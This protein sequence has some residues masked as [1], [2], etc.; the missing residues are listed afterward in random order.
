MWAEE[1][2]EEGRAVGALVLCWSCPSLRQLAPGFSS[3]WGS[4]ST[5]GDVRRAASVSG[6]GGLGV[7]WAQRGTEVKGALSCPTL[8][9]PMDRTV[10]GVLQ[11]RIL[12]WVAFPS[13]RGSSQPRDGTQVS[14][15]A[16][17]FFTS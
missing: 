5:G 10:H 9:D 11:A 14:C 6:L 15:I 8:C 4:M 2:Q 7:L 1:V 3:R 12:E 16:G 17:G 13:S